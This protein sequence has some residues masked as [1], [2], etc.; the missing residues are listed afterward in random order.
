MKK[1]ILLTMCMVLIGAGAAMADQIFTNSTTVYGSND[2]PYTYGTPSGDSNL[3]VIGDID[4]FGTSGAILDTAGMF[5]I[6]TNWNPAKDGTIGPSATNINV[7]TAWLFIKTGTNTYAIDLDGSNQ[8]A[9]VYLNPT[10]ITHSSEVTTDWGGTYGKWLGGVN[11][12][13]IPVRASGGTLLH[14]DVTWTNGSEN[15]GNT[16]AVDL[17]GILTADP[18]SFLWGT[19][20][21][22][23]G[24]FVGGSDNG[25]PLPPS[26]L[27]LGSGLLGLVGLGW[28]RR[29]TN[30]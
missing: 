16:V 25:V 7:T 2:Y 29:Q 3:W 30:V 19:A 14:T 28:R 24:S 1:V 13:L 9:T 4:W 15:L 21:C 20:T 11:G 8:Q 6:T 5:T 22:A 17:N 10:T 12:D 23:N 27:L 26:A 18:W